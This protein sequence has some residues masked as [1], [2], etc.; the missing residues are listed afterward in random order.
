[1]N[2]A[3]A[4]RPAEPLALL[5]DPVPL[6]VELDGIGATDTPAWPR[7]GV[8]VSARVRAL[9]AAVRSVV[10]HVRSFWDHLVRSVALGGGRRL[11]L[12]ASGS[13]RLR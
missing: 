10:V 12:D 3:A 13:Y 1:M 4:A 7:D 8:A 11:E 6:D 5:P 9:L 2:D